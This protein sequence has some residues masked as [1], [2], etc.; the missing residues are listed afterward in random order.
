MFVISLYICIMIIDKNIPLYFRS[1]VGATK[2]LEEMI[3][4]L[5]VNDSTLIPAQNIRSANIYRVTLSYILKKRGILHKYSFKKWDEDH[6]RIWR[7]K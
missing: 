1:K 2:F 4:L 6:Y 3:S 7:I 5:E